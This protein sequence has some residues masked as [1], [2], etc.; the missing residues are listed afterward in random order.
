[1]KTIGEILRTA[2]KDRGL[3]TGEL[4][5][6]TKIDTRHIEAIEEN[7]FKSLPSATFTKG[8]VRNL[9]ISLGKDP[10]EWVAL[11]RR[12]YHAIT[13][14]NSPQIRRARRFSLGSL[15]QSQTLLIGLGA[16]VFSVYLAFQYRAVITPPPLEV[17]S[18][19][20]DA[21][22]VSPV[23][24]EGKT[25]SGTTVTVNDDL[26]I[27]PDAEGRF[28]TK[29]NLSPGGNEIKV[30]VINRFG[31]TTSKTIPITILSQ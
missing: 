29:L 24:V 14:S 20:K 12:D 9:A 11:L 4:S 30:D 16:V 7:D 23:V 25:A 18:P 10:N 26:K 2:R 8:F 27:T 19:A 5:G 15:L 22:L 13:P 28:M 21:V 17:A 6:I 31:R 3:T 1:M